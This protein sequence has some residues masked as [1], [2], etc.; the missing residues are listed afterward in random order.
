MN[1]LKNV[2]MIENVWKI[3]D[4]EYNLFYRSTI[5]TNANFDNIYYYDDKGKLVNVYNENNDYI[6]EKIKNCALNKD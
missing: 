1:H 3:Q 5:K 2:K 4:I 6:L